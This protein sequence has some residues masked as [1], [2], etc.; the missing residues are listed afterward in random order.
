MATMSDSYEPKC[1]T[2]IHPLHDVP[3][4]KCCSEGL[5]HIEMTLTVRISLGML[6]AY[7]VAMTLMLG[8]H[9]LNLAGVFRG[10]R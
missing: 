5:R 4:Q 9:V 10:W 1:F 3:E 6:R 2:V 8:Y 7:L